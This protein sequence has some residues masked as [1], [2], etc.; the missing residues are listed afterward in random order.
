MTDTKRG[1][2][3]R[4]AESSYLA[5][6]EYNP[7]WAPGGRYLASAGEDQTV[8]VWNLETGQGRVLEGHTG[9]VKRL[10]FSPD[11]TRLASAGQDTTV[12]LWDMETGR[13]TPLHGHSEIVSQIGFSPDGQ[14]D[15]RGI[16]LLKFAAI[17]FGSLPRSPLL[18]HAVR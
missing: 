18:V 16:G 11:E 4:I 14:T 6:E 13:G 9:I 2:S 17:G 15:Q 1:K 5:Q 3:K 8:R 7:N 10:A 12:Y